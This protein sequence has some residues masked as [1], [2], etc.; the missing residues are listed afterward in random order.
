[1]ANILQR[2]VDFA[3]GK[4]YKDNSRFHSGLNKHPRTKERREED[5]E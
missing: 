4:L 2:I 5:E 3:S 1:M